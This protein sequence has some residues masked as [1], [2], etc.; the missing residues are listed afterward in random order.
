MPDLAKI[1][2]GL[3]PKAAKALARGRKIQGSVSA[4]HK[5]LQSDAIESKLNKIAT[6]LR[7]E[8]RSDPVELSR[9]RRLAS[10]SATGP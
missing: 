1:K 10:D 8:A 4:R 2:K 5:L 3:L 7:S 6:D 9:K